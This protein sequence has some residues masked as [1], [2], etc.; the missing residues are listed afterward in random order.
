[1]AAVKHPRLSAKARCTKLIGAIS[2]AIALL[3]APVGACPA[4]HAAAQHTI[5]MTFV[6]HA[7]SAANANHIIDTST[8]GPDI[9][10]LGEGQAAAVAN[11]LSANRYDGIY[12]STMVRTQET[13]AP[14]AQTLGEPVTVLAGL[15][16]I[17]AGDNEGLSEASAPVYPAPRVWLSGNRTMRIP[18]AINGEEFESRFSD[19]VKTIYDSGETNPAVFS[20]GEAI[21]YWVLMNVKNPDMRLVDSSLRNTGH[22]VVSGNPTDGWTLSNWDGT[23]VPAPTSH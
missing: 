5:I 20:H 1:M 3:A 18:G 19:A 9:T 10:A 11:E 8:P 16:E 6:R 21:T 13:A 15:R 17:E 14:L 23:P 12:A 22:V 4:A 7:Q 2:T